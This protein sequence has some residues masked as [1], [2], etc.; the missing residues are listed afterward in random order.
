MSRYPFTP[1][2]W[3]A[4]RSCVIGWD[5]ALGSYFAL[6]L[7]D[8]GR[9]IAAS[10]DQPPRFAKLDNLLRVINARLKGQLPPIQLTGECRHALAADAG[11]PVV[12][13]MAITAPGA[14]KP[15]PA[16]PTSR[17]PALLG[18]RAGYLDA[19]ELYDVLD[20]MAAT[21]GRLE[22]HYHTSIAAGADGETIARLH[23]ALGSLEIVCNL[24]ATMM[25]TPGILVAATALD[26][27]RELA[28]DAEH[29]LHGEAADAPGQIVH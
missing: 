24:L 18:T 4:D 2:G 9:I 12:N 28:A 1:P 21:F 11:K 5:D 14:E 8:A 3:P 19:E 23:G 15:P 17:E 25:Q 22:E 20:G 6:V 16:Q 27:F 10:G 26:P 29:L 7:D 13:A